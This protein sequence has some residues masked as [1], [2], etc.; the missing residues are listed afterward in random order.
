LQL[1]RKFNPQIKIY[2]LFGGKEDRLPVF[3]RILNPLLQNIFS[4]AQKGPEWNWKSSDL[5]VRLWF[6]DYG[7]KIDFEVLHQIEWDL[8]LFKS[9]E[10]I[11]L[12]IPPDGNGLTGLIPLE[13]VEERWDWTSEEPYKSEWLSLLS[14][15]RKKFGYNQ[16]PFA[17]LGPGFCLT[18][19]FIEKYAEIE[20]PELCHD[21]LRLPLFSQILG[22]PLYDTGFYPKWFDQVEQRFFNCLNK[23][24]S[25]LIIRNELKNP[26]GKRVFHPYRRLLKF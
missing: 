26:E 4:L 7:Q 15:A 12:E 5:A 9:I 6:K 1:L 18:R 3:E 19:K 8:L 11:Y 17:C 16:E 2:G 20:V 25:D 23:E 13:E 14:L 22:I 24:I 21:E 10:E